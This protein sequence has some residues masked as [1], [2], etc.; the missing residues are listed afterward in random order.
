MRRLLTVASLVATLLVAVFAMP[1]AAVDVDADTPAAVETLAT[2]PCLTDH[3]AVDELDGRVEAGRGRSFTITTT[4]ATLISVYDTAESLTVIYEVK[5]TVD[6]PYAVGRPEA[7][8]TEYTVECYTEKTQPG[9]GDPG[10]GDGD[11]G[12]D[13][14]FIDRYICERL[15]DRWRA[16][17][18]PVPNICDHDFGAVTLAAIQWR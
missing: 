17:G 8:T 5:V 12:R 2:P 14:G 16:R 1:A 11:G 9:S 18:L 7:V 10:D 13:R 15:K 4:D 6:T 3:A